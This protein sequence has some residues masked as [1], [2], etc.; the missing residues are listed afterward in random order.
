[1]MP[2]LR[3]GAALLVLLMVPACSTP[4]TA[5]PNIASADAAAEAAK[6]RE[7]VAKRVIDDDQRLW[8]V[9]YPLLAEG[10]ELCG[11]VVKTS[12][13]A[14][15]LARQYLSGE[16]AGMVARLLRLSDR[17]QVTRVYPGSPAEQAG[18]RAGDVLMKIGGEAVP[19]DRNAANLQALLDRKMVVGEALN[20]EI[21]R[22]SETLYVNPVPRERCDY[23]L[24]L[25]NE[26]NINAYADGENVIVTRGMMRFADS[27]QHLAVIIGHEIAHN[28]ME[29]IAAK[30]GNAIVAGAG[31]FLLDLGL[32]V[33]G[34]NTQGAFT[35][36][37]ARAGAGAY[38][39]GFEQEADYI[40]LY[41]LARAGYELEGAPEF[42]RL[43][44]AEHPNAIDQRRTHPTT[45]ERFLALE[46]TIEEIKA[47]QQNGEPLVPEI[48][49]EPTD[50]DG[51]NTLLE[52]AY[53][54]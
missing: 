44:A 22:N 19:S 47:K 39:V 26:A 13:G 52:S 42:W 12:L 8:R 20:I 28:A 15:I 23:N 3:W 17:P 7:L 6:Q 21:M 38:S 37:A 4:R 35:R 30:K 34:V 50:D 45:P 24:V 53:P 27:D 14:Q 5:S 16:H 51:E 9:G 36:A 41:F 2:A 18:M 10:A 1:M 25:N 32:A 29:H 33:L 48:L 46:Q 40:G 31:G 11:D 43:M 54:E 49:P